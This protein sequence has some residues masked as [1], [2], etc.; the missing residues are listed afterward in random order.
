VHCLF[1]PALANRQ[2]LPDNEIST[3][4][5]AIVRFGHAART[6]QQRPQHEGIPAVAKKGRPATAKAPF[7][8]KTTLQDRQA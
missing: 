4:T 5:L 2:T 6:P 1:A 7:L 8:N 3:L